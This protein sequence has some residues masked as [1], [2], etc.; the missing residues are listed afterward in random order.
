MAAAGASRLILPITSHAFLDTDLRG[1]LA[2]FT[3]LQLTK[4]VKIP[5]YLSQLKNQK[6]RGV[7][8]VIAYMQLKIG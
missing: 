4:E 6:N 5:V 3:P 1:V 8:E 7:E 2:S